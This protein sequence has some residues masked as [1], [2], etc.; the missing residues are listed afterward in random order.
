MQGDMLSC[1]PLLYD[2]PKRD[3]DIAL[4]GAP[5]C[6]DRVSL[7]GLHGGNASEWKVGG[8]KE[9]DFVW[10][11]A[12]PISFFLLVRFHPWEHPTPT[13]HTH[14]FNSCSEPRL[15]TSQWGVTLKSRR[16]KDTGDF[17]FVSGWL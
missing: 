16:G 13:Q 1:W 17:G 10:T 3:K 14:P 9:K 5:P 2:K 12:P 4:G 6:R 8:K 15:Y 7:I 11:S